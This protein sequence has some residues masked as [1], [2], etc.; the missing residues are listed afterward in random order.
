MQVVF[1]KL[2]QLSI[3]SLSIGKIWN[4]GRLPSSRSA[5]QSLTTIKVGDCNNLK[6]LI[7]SFMTASLVH[8]RDLFV[9]SCKAM[10]EIVFIE[11]VMGNYISF[12]K[13]EYLKLENL[14]NL[15]RFCGGDCVDCP[16]LLKLKISGCPKLRVFVTN[17]IPT[18]TTKKENE[19]LRSSVDKHISHHKV[20]LI[21]FC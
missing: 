4:N 14:P 10:K 7:P 15:E 20:I 12:P 16:S 2:D 5:F 19:N 18:T 8:L 11:H 17:N 1:P 9:G 21:C 13:L 6:G 3:F